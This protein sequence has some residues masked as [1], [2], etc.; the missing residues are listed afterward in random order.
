MKNIKNIIGGLSLLLF[1]S[2]SFALD[3]G[4]IVGQYICPDGNGAFVDIDM[5]VDY[6]TGQAPI[7][8]TRR[9]TKTGNVDLIYIADDIPRQ[10]DDW[11]ISAR[12]QDENFSILYRMY[13]ASNSPVWNRLLQLDNDQLLIQLFHGDEAIGSPESEIRCDRR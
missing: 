9:I 13:S 2:T 10:F 3:C 5:I 8:T 6:P 11:W 1:T 12:C 4:A 7:V